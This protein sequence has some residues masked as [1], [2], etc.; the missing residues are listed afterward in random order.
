MSR[1]ILKQ[2]CLTIKLHLFS[3]F[4]DRFIHFLIRFATIQDRLLRRLNKI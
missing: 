4:I 2:V 1:S 3:R